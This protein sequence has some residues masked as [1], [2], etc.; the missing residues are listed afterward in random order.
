MKFFIEIFKKKTIKKHSLKGVFCLLL[1]LS[2]NELLH[3]PAKYLAD[4]SGNK[5]KE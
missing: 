4:S 5:I 2:F 3:S 1:S